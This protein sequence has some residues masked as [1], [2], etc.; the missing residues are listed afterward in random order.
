MSLSPHPIRK[1]CRACRGRGAVQHP[2]G[3]LSE[4]SGSH[5]V[6][7]S[8]RTPSGVLLSVPRSMDRTHA[9]P[10]RTRWRWRLRMTRWSFV[11][12]AAGSFAWALVDS[13][14]VLGSLPSVMSLY[15]IALASTFGRPRRQTVQQ[16]GDID[17]RDL[18]LSLRDQRVEA[19]HLDGSQIRSVADL[20]N[21]LDG[22]LGGFRYP[23]DPW[24]KA[25]AHIDHEARGA[26]RR[27]VIWTNAHQLVEADRECFEEFLAEW[28]ECM[29]PWGKGNSTL[30]VD[31]P[32]DPGGS[33]N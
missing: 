12:F 4:V 20:A 14:E 18:A 16:M 26:G 30:Y 13:S 23:E 21:E 27:A 11:F 33:L 6:Q 25:M 19:V 22:A 3:R 1:S 9:R 29:P 17:G 24:R 2:R 7:L 10:N 15:V 8:S 5:A 31:V 28:R 32:V